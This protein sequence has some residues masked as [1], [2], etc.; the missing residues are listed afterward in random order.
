[1]SSALLTAAASGAAD[2]S[3]E[4]WWLVL[5]KAVAVFAFLVLKVI[6]VIWAER[7]IIGRMQ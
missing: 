3:E 4:T 7:R 1:M 6:V 2:F 5:I